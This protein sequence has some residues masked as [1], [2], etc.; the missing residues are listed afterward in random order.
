MAKK[1]KS[2]KTQQNGIADLGPL[3]QAPNWPLLA[4]AVA[5]LALTAYLTFTSLTGGSVRGCSAGSGCDVVLASRW[6]TLFGLPTAL[7]GFLAYAGLAA[8]AFIKPA[9]KH[10]R[11]AWTAA[12]LGVS[13]S[14]YLTTVSLT[15]LKATCPYCLTSL[16]L[17]IGTLALTT[18]Q[19]PAGLKSFSWRRWLTR[20]VP[21]AAIFV[22]ALH[23]QYVVV[24]TEPVN[25]MAKPLAEHLTTI[26]AKFYGASWCEHC[27]QQKKYFG[28]YADRLPYIECKPGSPS[29]PMTKP[30]LDNY[31]STFPTWVINGKR[32]EGVLTVTDLAEL[33]GF[34][35][36]PSAS[37]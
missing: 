33:S 7:W 35:A 21:V 36:P 6:A 13:Y 29:A 30:C 8:I 4:I 15:V 32:V 34:K 28:D 37:N 20:R 24:P 18:Y 2:K 26:G 3:R 25:P 31:I 17:M 16:S 1:S 23:L 5:G 14:V 22:F 10:W 12:L 27:Q 11:Y 19:R 9:G